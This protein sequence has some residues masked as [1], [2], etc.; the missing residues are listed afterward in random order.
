MG[1][2]ASQ[3]RLLTI[4]ARM[5][6]VEYKAQNIMNQKTALAT[7][8][9]ELYQNY[10]DALDAKKIQVAYTDGVSQK[11]VDATFASLCKYDKNRCTDYALIDSNS[12][13]VIVSEEAAKLYNE[14][15][16]DTDKYAFAWAMLGMADMGT[17][18]GDC[19]IDSI[20][21]GTCNENGGEDGNAGDLALSE[22][23]MKAYETL[24]A[25]GGNSQLT[26]LYEEVEKVLGDSN[27]T[28]AEKYEA[29]NNFRDKLYS[30]SNMQ[31]LYDYMR[32]S[33]DDEENTDIENGDFDSAYPSNI[34]DIKDE[35]D[36]Y[37]RLFECIEQA[38]GCISVDTLTD[39]ED[40]GNEWF[41]RKINSGAM[42]IQVYNERGSN[43]GWADTSV[44]TSTSENYLKEVQDEAD[45]K[46]AEAEYEYELGKISDKDKKFDQDLN[47]L[48]T[49]RTSLKTEM[50]SIKNV[51][52]ENEERTFGIFS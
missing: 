9:D 52:K 45:L 17:W 12:G 48:E 11:Y 47:K 36:Y 7:Q 44:A 3:A 14:E 20:G 41:N 50:D 4:T 22:A 37:T 34:D 24:T 10:I 18:S 43:K 40:A 42:T 51:I 19:N 2:A 21:V 25:E 49:E 23:E 46:K 28:R 1:M 15:G 26:S 27:A 30:S 16:F 6:D 35:F 5:H 32:L 8:K 33:K 31:T 29:I 38:G 39:G 13:K